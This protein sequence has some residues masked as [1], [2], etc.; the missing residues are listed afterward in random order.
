MRDML[1]RRLRRLHPAHTHPHGHSRRK[2][3]A[4]FSSLPDPTSQRHT[5]H[6]ALVISAAAFGTATK[7]TKG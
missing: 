6:A 1:L 4:A 3:G 5:P 7:R 2:G